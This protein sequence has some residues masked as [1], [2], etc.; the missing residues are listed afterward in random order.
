MLLAIV[1]I[2]FEFYLDKQNIHKSMILCI[3]VIPKYRFKFSIFQYGFFISQLATLATK[4][5]L[6]VL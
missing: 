1:N 4:K 2:F 5:C 3:R 6:D